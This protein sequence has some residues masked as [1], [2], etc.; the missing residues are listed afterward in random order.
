MQ[1][2]LIYINLSEFHLTQHILLIPGHTEDMKAV[3]VDIRE[4]FC[5]YNDIATF[6]WS[7]NREVDLL[8]NSLFNKLVD[9]N[10]IH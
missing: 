1:V 5:R 3:S 6:Q 7:G 4:E 2:D 9:P 8:F 10:T